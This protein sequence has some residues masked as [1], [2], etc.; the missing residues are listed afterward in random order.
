MELF[1]FINKND[2]DQISKMK[3]NDLQKLFELLN[4][5]YLEL[6]KDLN[7]DNY[8]TFGLELEFEYANIRSIVK[9]L[10]MQFPDKDRKSVV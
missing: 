9:N 2:N 6:R 7:I 3:G 4:R 10:D 8:I 5:Y 1:E